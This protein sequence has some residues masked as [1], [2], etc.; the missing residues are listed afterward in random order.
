MFLMKVF[1]NGKRLF[2]VLNHPLV[3]VPVSIAYIELALHKS[4]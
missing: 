4:H 2:S 3:Q 1:A